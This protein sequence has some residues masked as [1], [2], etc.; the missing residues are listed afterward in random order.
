PGGD[1]T[2]CPV[3]REYSEARIP[4]EEIPRAQ[5]FR[6]RVAQALVRP[7][8]TEFLLLRQREKQAAQRLLSHRALPGPSGF[9]AP[10]RFPEK[11]LLPA[12]LSWKTLL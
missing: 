2:A 10:E 1:P 4:G 7:H 11:M 6:L 12:A 8:P 9:P 5:L 3:F